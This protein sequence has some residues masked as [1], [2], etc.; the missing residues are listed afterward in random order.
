MSAPDTA[1]AL[2]GETR[3]V[4]AEEHS[5]GVRT[6][7]VEN[8]GHVGDALER[9]ARRLAG[10]ATDFRQWARLYLRRLM[11]V[12]ALSGLLAVGIAA[13]LPPGL[14]PTTVTEWAVLGLIGAAGWPAWVAGARGYRR[15]HVGVGS[16]ELRAVVQATVLIIVV[17]ALP[18]TWL[19]IDGVL[20]T[21]VVA[22]PFAALASVGVRIG[23]R[24]RLRRSQRAGSNLR[25][26]IMVGTPEAVQELCSAVEREPSMGMRVAGVCVPSEE[27]E[28]ARRMGLPVVGD[29]DHVAAIAS[30]LECHGVAVTGAERPTFVRHLAWSLEGVDADLLVHPGLLDVAR[31]RMHIQPYSGAPM[32]HVE[33]PRFDGWTR[34]VKRA[35]DLVITGVGLLIISPLLAALALLIKIDD[36]KGPVIFKQ[37]RIGVD[38]R[39]F[40]MLKFRSMCTD[41]EQKLAALKAQNEG[42]G[43]LFKIENDPRV[44]RVGRVLRK[45]SL[46]ELPQLF[47]VLAGSMS[48]VGPRPP[49]KSEVDEYADPVRRRLKVVPGLT[50]L[51]QVSGRS[52]LTWEES[53]RL[54]LHY[55]ENWS[56]GLD[57]MII[58]KTAHAVLA[59]RGAF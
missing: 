22:A 49:L 4:E 23:W 56:I 19:G 18:A 48:L 14:H 52:L 27:M 58:F 1:V 6:T 51:W 13:L 11:A 20:G 42:A 47:N 8:A 36:R 10:R 24:E 15:H 3:L 45:Y 44:T 25:R 41:A 2:L 16:A 32:L 21:V 12:D 37:T 57:L 35:M 5:D 33:Q 39:P 7:A 17:T 46:D 9:R 43:P 40:T 30:E 50:G 53:V 31:P 34:R 55:V 38:G 26:M 29:V 28:R 59:K 54:D